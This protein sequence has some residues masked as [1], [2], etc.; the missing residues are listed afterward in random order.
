MSI[1]NPVLNGGDVMEKRIWV[2]FGL[3][4]LV[5]AMAPVQAGWIMDH[6]TAGI[7]ENPNA[8]FT[9]GGGAVG[10]N[11]TVH[12]GYGLKFSQFANTDQWVHYPIPT[13]Y[14]TTYKRILFKFSTETPAYDYIKTV[15]VWDG[16]TRVAVF[17]PPTAK[18]WATTNLDT[19]MEVKLTLPGSGH[20]FRDGLNIC[21][22]PYVDIGSP[23]PIHMF[24]SFRIDNVGVADY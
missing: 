2:L 5:F 12:F 4:L 18:A 21:I 19:P 17:N 1:L 13:N 6:G 24:G 14:P 11:S 3:A 9:Q 23:I 7:F 15:H 10:V 16:R 22:N 8:V 20:V